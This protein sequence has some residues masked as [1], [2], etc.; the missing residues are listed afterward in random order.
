[1]QMSRAH[2][3]A[4]TPPLRAGRSRPTPQ[5]IMLSRHSVGEGGGPSP[6]TAPLNRD[7]HEV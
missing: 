6:C 7:A 2:L 5:V 4:Q 3:L 1:M